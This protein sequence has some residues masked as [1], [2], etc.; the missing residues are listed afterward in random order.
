M[1]KEFSSLVDNKT[2]KLCELSA[3][4]I[5]LGG[6]WVFALKKDEKDGIVK[7]KARY[8]AKCFFQTF[9]SDY[10]ETFAPT[11]KLSSIRMPLAFATHF[12]CV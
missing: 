11:A 7:Y 6:R 9:G 12:H 5:S 10:S 2:W 1:T 4:N 8:V 3:H